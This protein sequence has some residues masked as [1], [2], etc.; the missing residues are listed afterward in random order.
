MLNRN[1]YSSIAICLTTYAL[2]VVKRQTIYQIS[3]LSWLCYNSIYVWS[4]II[5]CYYIIYVILICCCFFFNI[6]ALHVHFPW[7]SRPKIGRN[8][9]FRQV[10]WKPCSHNCFVYFISI[11]IDSSTFRLHFIFTTHKTDRICL[12]RNQITLIETKSHSCEW[13]TV[14][15]I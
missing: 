13:N 11:N 12:R 8:V 4:Y 3:L 9:Y 14:H 10:Y 2:I 1:H 6:T 15:R 5:W 7:G